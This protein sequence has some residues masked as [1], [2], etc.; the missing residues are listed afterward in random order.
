MVSPSSLTF[1]RVQTAWAGDH[2]AV[3]DRP[4]DN[5]EMTSTAG[6]EVTPCRQEPELLRGGAGFTSRLCPLRALALRGLV[7]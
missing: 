7:E 6:A 4:A 2:V 3:E 5:A 1:Y